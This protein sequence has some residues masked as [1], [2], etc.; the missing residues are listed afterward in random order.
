[1]AFIILLQDYIHLVFNDQFTIFIIIITL[2][3]V[4]IIQA[5]VIFIKIIIKDLIIVS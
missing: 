4:I 2:N 3:I 5:I 1:M